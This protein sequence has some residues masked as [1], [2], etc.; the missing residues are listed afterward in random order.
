MEGMTVASTSG[1]GRLAGRHVIITG[2]ASGIGKAT[3][4]LFHQEGAKLA[5]IDRDGDRL[6]EV[7]HAL[8]AVALPLDLADNAAVAGAVERA[9]AGMGAVDGLVNCAAV[10]S[11]AMIEDVD[12]PLL[13][14]VTSINFMAPI[15]LCAAAVPHMRKAGRGTIVN[16]ASGQGVLPNAPRTTLY[17]GTKGGL[18][19]F[20]KSLAFEVAPMIRANA[21]CPGLTNTP[22]G[23]ALFAGWNGPPEDNP[24]LKAYAL[25]RMAEPIEQAQAILFLTSDES[26]YVTG[27]L[28]AVD[29]GRCFH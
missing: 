8:D 20:T 26:S 9:A 11:G 10:G 24:A 13:T 23:S 1:S 29:G 18:I 2:A 4:E 15:L 27:V 6:S 25:R 16:I 19:A 12:L 22:M 17:G 3:A 14:M 21:I 5:L 7:A 28:L